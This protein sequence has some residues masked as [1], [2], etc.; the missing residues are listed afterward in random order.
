MNVNKKNKIVIDKYSIDEVE[1][2]M[3]RIMIMRVVAIMMNKVNKT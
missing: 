2:I 1:K 3:R